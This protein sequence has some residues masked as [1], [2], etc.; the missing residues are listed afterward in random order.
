MG[1][2]SL[3]A[4]SNWARVRSGLISVNASPNSLSKGASGNGCMH[5][6]LHGPQRRAWF[7]GIGTFVRITRSTDTVSLT[8]VW[9]GMARRPITTAT[10]GAPGVAATT[11][12]VRLPP[13]PRTPKLIQTVQFLVQNHA[14]F[15]N[16][17]QRYDSNVV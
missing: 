9:V 12:P 11:E 2:S 10:G 4:T 8:Q 15:D 1:F 3:G 14:M 6:C 5:Q 7:R 17:C 16:I 13:G